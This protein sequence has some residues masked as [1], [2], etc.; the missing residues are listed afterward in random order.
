M[1]TLPYGRVHD[2]VGAVA[3][4]LLTLH[5]A[6]TMIVLE[7]QQGIAT[8]PTQSLADSTYG[9]E[10]MIVLESVADPLLTLHMADTMIV[11]E[12]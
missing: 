12:Q 1:L 4:P 8:A 11:L 2:C 3:D 5:M 7:S 6:D 9:R 10:S